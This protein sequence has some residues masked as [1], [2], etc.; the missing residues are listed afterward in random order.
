VLLARRENA[1]SDPIR[2]DQPEEPAIEAT[3]AA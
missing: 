1:P 2:A 3:P